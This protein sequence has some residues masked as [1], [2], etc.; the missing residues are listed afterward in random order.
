MYN[1]VIIKL[2]HV[3]FSKYLEIMANLSLW[4]E[5]SETIY[6]MFYNQI[7]SFLKECH[8]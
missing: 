5:N 4:R 2:M 7:P 8:I 6:E 1:N 3:F